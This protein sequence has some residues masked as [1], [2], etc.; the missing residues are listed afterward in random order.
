MSTATKAAAIE[1]RLAYEI[2]RGERVAGSQLPPVRELARVFRVTPPTIQ[3]VI[4]RLETSGL[5]SARRGSGVTVREPRRSGDLAL[6]PLWFEALAD[7]PDRA[8]AMLA[9]VLEL[10][11]VVA[12][13]LF[14]TGARS[15]A[16]AAASLAPL[17][18]A[19]TSAPT[20]EARAVADLE[21]TAAA[22]DATSQFAV[23]AVFHA[24][25]RVIRDVPQIAWAV[26]GDPAYYR[27]MLL[28]LA[29]GDA[30]DAVLITWDRRSVDRYRGELARGVRRRES[31][32]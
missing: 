3:R 24:T 16:R 26:Y 12:A 18:A 17:M 9:D 11:R 5:V 2:L 20:V 6:L 10:R 13:H 1:R 7:Q 25:A 29:S 27:R 30:P 19:A 22:I 31:S 15:L 21:L 8:A 32:R 23:A 28:R 14:T 4:E